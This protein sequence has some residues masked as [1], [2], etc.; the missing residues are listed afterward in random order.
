[1]FY[2]IDTV[3]EVRRQFVDGKKQADFSRNT[4]EYWSCAQIV[5]LKC[6]REKMSS[7]TELRRAFRQRLTEPGIIVAPG[8]GDA[9]GATLIERNGF[10]AAYMSGYAVEATYGSPDVGLLTMSEM[11]ERAAQ[12]CERVSIPVISDADTGYGN[13]VNV[14]RTVREF[15][16]AGVAAIQIEDQSLPKKC[17]SMPGKAVVSTQEM[18][19]KIKAFVDTRLDPNFLLIART[20]VASIEGMN[21][22]ADRLAA[23]REAGADILMALGPYD[24][25]QA[26]QFIKNATGPIAY[27]NSESFTMP[28][29][30]AK[31]LETLGVKLVIFP[32]SLTLAAAHAQQRALEVIRAQGTTSEYAADAMLSWKDCNK[33][34]GLEKIHHIETQYGPASSA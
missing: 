31:E 1:L 2:K 20:D 27:L 19:G 13:V 26:R 6:I 10:E 28:M 11:V 22:V 24:V 33:L 8:A 29:M 5:G 12:M 14:T 4:A 15:E 23:Y 9:M 3:P 34:L 17:G 30:P 16:R 25:N 32:L 7:P 21:A 18:V